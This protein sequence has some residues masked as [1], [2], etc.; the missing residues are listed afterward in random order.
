MVQEPVQGTNPLYGG[1][2]EKPDEG[3]HC[4]IGDAAGIS[5]EAELPAR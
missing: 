1:K 5:T 3:E 4:P 2:F